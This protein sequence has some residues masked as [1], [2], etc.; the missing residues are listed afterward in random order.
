M[1]C[2]KK[3]GED[4][5]RYEV[6]TENWDSPVII[7]T[8]VQFL[9]ILFDQKTSAVGR[10]RALCDSVIVIDE[11]QSV[12]KKT[13]E[14]FSAALNFLNRYC[15][16]T[17]ILSS[18]TQPCFENLEYALKISEPADLVQLSGSQKKVF[19]R[20]EIINCVTPYGMDLNA[21]AEFLQ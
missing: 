11:V 10:M 16:A 13:I 4:L 15:N 2:M 1:L 17:I 18:A 5:D 6:L 8:L 3:T 9:N 19:Q 7:S 14:M 21:C 20:A 12:P